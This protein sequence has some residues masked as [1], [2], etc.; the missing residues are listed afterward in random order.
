MAKPQLEYCLL[1]MSAPCECTKPT[2]PAT[3]KASARLAKP[4][5]SEIVSRVPAK[6]AGLS[7]AKKLPDTVSE[8]EER[9]ALTLLC[10]SGLVRWEDVEANA[11]QLNMTATEIRLLV[12]RQKR[13]TSQEVG[14]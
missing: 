10:R 4:V 7:A 2:K 6:R 1:C 12:W 14:N 5:E 3:Q 8:I 11:R 9:N 13:A